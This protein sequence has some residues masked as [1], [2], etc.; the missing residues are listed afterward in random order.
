MTETP[1]ENGDLAWDSFE[2]DDTE[3]KEAE[4]DIEHDDLRKEFLLDHLGKDAKL[5]GITMM[6]N[7]LCAA[8]ILTPEEERG[9]AKAAAEGDAKAR[10]MLIVSNQ[11]LVVHVA[12][13]YRNLGLDFVDLV[14]EGNVGL[15]RAVDKFEY[16][17]GFKLSTYAVW[18][19]R[20]AITRGLANTGN[21]IRIPV[22]KVKMLYTLRRLKEQFQKN[23]DNEKPSVKW[24][25]KKMEISEEEVELLLKQKKP[26]TMNAPIGKDPEGGTFADVLPDKNTPKN[27]V[28][29]HREETMQQIRLALQN[30]PGISEE[31]IRLF[32][33]SSGLHDGTP[34]DPKAVAEFMNENRGEDERKWTKERTKQLI[35]KIKRALR[36]NPA[37]AEFADN[38]EGESR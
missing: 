23:H 5:D 18:W 30:V 27:D 1:Q 21:E 35:G 11:R 16:Q 26:K 6:M 32:S 22:H 31:H 38:E 8:P 37:L 20:Q 33:V 2:P 24:L 4:E 15:I 7:A 19:I 34:R 13:R 25:A 14:S 3:L 10:G 17:R 36:K 28:E 29:L 9:L 12:K